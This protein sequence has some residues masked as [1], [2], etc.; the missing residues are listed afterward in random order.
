MK[1]LRLEHPAD[2]IFGKVEFSEILDEFSDLLGCI[3]NSLNLRG[4]PPRPRYKRART[5]P[6]FK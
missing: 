6:E 1:Q 2:F 5:L 3:V 4:W